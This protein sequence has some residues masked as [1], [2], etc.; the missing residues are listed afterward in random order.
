[1]NAEDRERIIEY[2][3]K[4][5][6]IECGDP[7]P[8]T[9]MPADTRATWITRATSVLDTSGIL[10]CLEDAPTSAKKRAML[11]RAH[12]S[13]EVLDKHFASEEALQQISDW[14]DGRRPV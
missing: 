10:M 4:L 6:Y 13:K 3:A 11:L 1:M 2:V 8:W 7:W 14:E 5:M 9:H 12:N